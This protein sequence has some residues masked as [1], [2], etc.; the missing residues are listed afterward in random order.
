MKHIY[1]F[2]LLLSHSLLYAQDESLYDNNKMHEIRISFDQNNWYETLENYYN[3]S[4]WGAAE[5]TYLMGTINIDGVEIDSIGV[6]FKGFTSYVSDNKKPIKIDLNEFVSGKHYN[7]IKKFNL[8]NGFGD[9]SMQRDFICYQMH[10]DLGSYA[11]RTAYAKLYVNDEYYGCMLLV[12]QVDKA[13]LSHRFK[14]DDGN[15][16]KNV[17]WCNFEDRGTSGNN[18]KP[19]FELRTNRESEDYQ[20]IADMVQMLYN[21]NSSKEDFER[22]FN[23]DLLIRTLMV[24]VFTNNWDSNLNHGRN[25]YMYHEPN[26]DKIHWLPW[27]YNFALGGT[28]TWNEQ[29]SPI[30]WIQYS[31]EV[32]PEDFQSRKL[33]NQ[34]MKFDDFKQRYLDV[35]CSATEEI[36]TQEYFSKTLDHNYSIISDAIAA[37]NNYLYTKEAFEYD[38]NA[39]NGIRNYLSNRIE[40]LKQDMN[41]KNYCQFNTSVDFQDITINEL[42]ASNDS[43]SGI[44]DEFGEYN[45]WI[46][47]YN[48]TDQDIDL[49][50]YHIS[51]NPENDMK[52]EF[53]AGSVIPANRYMI[54][55]AD[56]DQE[57]G[58]F[59]TNFKLSKGGETLKL[60]DKNGALMDEVTFEEQE[61]NIAYARNPNGT[62][63]FVSQTATFNANN[64]SVGIAE[65]NEPLA[66]K[67]FPNPATDI[68]QISTEKADDY[69]I[70]VVNNLGKIVQQISAQGQDLSIN[71][72]DLPSG[73]YTLVLSN[74]RQA[75][76][77]QPLVVIR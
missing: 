30:D 4:S 56:E 5:H 59:H 61:T 2:A 16:Y 75:G 48:N 69:E 62:G 72:S 14:N 50:G 23:V 24:D 73:T 26:G 34:L 13:F 57:Q 19:P 70:S 49:T 74:S 71:V 42:V 77:I 17:E 28:F 33:L 6:R 68:V 46:E 8:N 64:E 3:L 76:H 1:L 38:I 15:L 27:D 29:G 67:V 32:I 31:F 43:L 9:P 63:N 11:P 52:W 66:I 39:D 22:Y 47:L 40:F 65:I 60:F 44:A 45:D 21:G 53:P 36:F 10:R 7:G 25:W 58:P 18:Y 20:I 35:F 41:S 54:L 37:D 51:D 55:W 12:E